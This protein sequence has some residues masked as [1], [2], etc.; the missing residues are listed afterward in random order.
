MPLVAAWHSGLTQRHQHLPV[1]AELDDPM[2]EPAARLRCHGDRFRTGAVSCP[3][4]ALF[5][6][7]KPMRPDEH[8]RAEALD[9]I[10]A[11]IE[12][13]DGVDVLHAALFIE[14]VDAEPASV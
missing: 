3:D 7:V 8:A 6:D 13:V 9:D 4:I 5:V 14:A 10:A 1:G 11:R 2:A 12:P